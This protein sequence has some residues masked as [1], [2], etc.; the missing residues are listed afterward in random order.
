M[1]MKKLLGLFGAIGLVT[2]ASSSVVSCFG[3]PDISDLID[4]DAPVHDIDYFKF[5]ISVTKDIIEESDMNK[6]FPDGVNNKDL[7]QVIVSGSLGYAAQ[8]FI[9]SLNKDNAKAAI[10]AAM[11]DF[12]FTAL[13]ENDQAIK[14]L[15]NISLEEDGEMTKG[16]FVTKE[17]STIEKVLITDKQDETKEKTLM[18]NWETTP[19]PDPDPTN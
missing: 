12:K 6:Y 18:V 14:D 3:L 2:S 17:D 15:T 9:T 7:L 10:G 4:K 11:F 8:Y 16:Q 13:D 19:T 1:N 5:Q